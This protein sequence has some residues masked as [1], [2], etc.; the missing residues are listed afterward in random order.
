MCVE[1]NTPVH[2]N[3]VSDVSFSS[4]TEAHFWWIIIV[5]FTDITDEASPTIWSSCYAINIFVFK[6]CTLK[7]SGLN[8]TQIG[9]NRNPDLGQ[10][11]TDANRVKLTR[12]PGST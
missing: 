7:T 11:A 8:L 5:Y 12:T 3:F 2:E 9:L 10:Y 4:E 1:C 6:A